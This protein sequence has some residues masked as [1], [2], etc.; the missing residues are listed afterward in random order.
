GAHPPGEFLDLDHFLH[1]MRLYK[2]AAEIRAMTTA[3]EIS[4]RAHRRAMLA[5]APGMY[6]YELEAEIQHECAKSGA[7][8]QAYNAIVG[9]GRNACILHYI[10]NADKLRD[11]DLVLIDAGC[12]Y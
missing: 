7:R 4:A 11:G 1:D 10:E 6:E 8:F 12:E 2:S 3:A 9:G 5:C